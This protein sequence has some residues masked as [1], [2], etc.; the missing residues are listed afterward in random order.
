MKLDA[1]AACARARDA[2]V[3]DVRTPTLFARGHL[4]GSGNLERADFD[5]RRS[6][7]PPRDAAVLIVAAHPA[8][9][10]D[11][12]AALT[13]R[14]YKDVRWFDGDVAALSTRECGWDTG[15]AQRLWRPNPF[16]AEVLPQI[17]HSGRACD[18]AAG[19][20]RDAVYLAT[21]GFD[22]EA[23]DYDAEALVR[24]TA[25]A[26][27]SGVRISTL[28]CDLEQPEVPLPEAAW[29]L[30]VCVRYLHRPLL[31]RLARAL[32]PGGHLVYETF[33]AGQEQFGRPSRAR[34]LLQPGEL[35]AAFPT[36]EVLRY[37]EPSPPAG[38]WTAQL[39]ARRTPDNVETSKPGTY[40]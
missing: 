7:L 14:G 31:P 37:D 25:L 20:G 28:I 29:D 6:E 3:L 18:L 17:P 16:L 27:R 9:A 23:W 33:R 24:A 10:A 39:L 15:P 8:A 2:I 26:A 12:A 22:V 32:R 40:A 36:L 21:M 13:E 35:R 34:F 38:P 4:P 11:A 30:I 5:E 19:A 1:D